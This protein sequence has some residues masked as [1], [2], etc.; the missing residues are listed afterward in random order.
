MNPGQSTLRENQ[1]QALLVK[2]RTA[3]NAL[4]AGLRQHRLEAGARAHLERALAHLREATAALNG[5]PGVR[6]TLQ[7]AEELGQLERACQE[8]QQQPPPG[9]TIRPFH[10]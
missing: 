1:R 7:L 8:R 6:S 5:N 2:L 3:E 10:H 4:R 9:F